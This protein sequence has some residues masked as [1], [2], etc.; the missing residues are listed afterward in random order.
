MTRLAVLRDPRFALLTGARTVSVL[1][2]GFAAVALAFAVLALGL[3]A[4]LWLTLAAA[5]VCGIGSDV[6]GVLWTTTLQREVAAGAI[7]RVSSWDLFGSLAVAPIGIAVAGPLAAAV[8]VRPALVA[9][10]VLMVLVTVAALAAPDVRRLP[11][12]HAPVA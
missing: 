8:G 10:A 6:F 1:G 9:S 7:S 3:G 12:R 2:N 11:A 5:L 4:P